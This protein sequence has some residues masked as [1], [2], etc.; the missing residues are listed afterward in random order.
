MSSRVGESPVRSEPLILLVIAVALAALMAVSSGLT[1]FWDEW[2]VILRGPGWSADTL[3]TPLNEH[4][5]LGP[6]VIYKLLLATVGLES[7]WPYRAVN[8]ALMLA[9]VALV[10]AF[11][12][13]RLGQLVAL[14]LALVLALLGPAWEDL[15]WA[16]GVS[17]HGSLAAG[18]GALLLLERARERNELYACALLVVS[19]AFSSLGLVFV[20][21][22]LIDVLTSG[23]P[24]RAACVAAIPI[25]LYAV[26]YAVYGGEA[27]SA[28]S[29]ENLLDAP[30]YVAVAASAALASLTGLSGISSEAL[31]VSTGF[32]QPLLVFVAGGVIYLI[33]RRPQRL[34]RR[35][36]I[37]L[38]VAGAF[39]ALAALNEAPGREAGASRYQ[40]IA[41]VFVVL[42]A[43]ELLRGERLRGG[44]RWVFA[45][46]CGLAV[47]SNLGALRFGEH[48]L[49]DRTDSTLASLSALEGARDAIDPEMVIAGGAPGSPFPSNYTAGQYF[50]AVDRWGSPVGSGESPAD[51]PEAARS[52]ADQLLAAALGLAAAPSAPDG[53]AGDACTT[54]RPDA[55]S[56]VASLELPAGGARLSSAR[57]MTIALRRWSL[58]DF[59]VELG[60]AAPGAGV[61]VAIPTD[62]FDQPWSAAVRTAGDVEVCPLGSG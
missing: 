4:P 1:F 14:G 37:L 12:R 22:A 53:Q 44:W 38:A 50:A 46:A 9:V 59:P 47:V 55:A 2:N 62:S 18:L 60:S 5:Y 3:L 24:I 54:A 35:L 15:L 48:Y 29:L 16:A 10:Y 26:W 49:R 34:S 51:G 52:G 6:V 27:D 32:G 23:R 36:W 45:A 11:V 61:D 13:P 58:E 8:L 21:G 39:W 57:E 43:A 30:R 31:G 41:A 42:I 40:L 33:A 17:F 19:V 28:V 25:V 7:N 56:G 20:L